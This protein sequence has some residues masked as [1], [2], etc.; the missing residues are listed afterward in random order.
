M[1]TDQIV[2]ENKIVAVILTSGDKVEF[3]PN[4]AQIIA[5]KKIIAGKGLDGQ[6]IIIPLENVLYVQVQE[7]DS[8]KAA[9]KTIGLIALIGV[10]FGIIM[11]ATKQSCPFIYSYDGEQYVFDGEPLGGTVSKGL[12]RSDFSRLDFLKESD[13][14]YKLMVTNEVLETQFIDKINLH[15]V[16]HP[17]GTEVAADPLG[18]LHVISQPQAPLKA[19]DKAGND[20][21]KFVNNRDKVN[22]QSTLPSDSTAFPAEMR[23]QLTFTF[24][25]P[26]GA[27]KAHIL[28]NAGTALWGSRMIREILLLRGEKVKDWYADIDAD[29]E[30]YTKLYNWNEREELF[31][32]KVWVKEKDGWHV[33]EVFPAGG[34]LVLEDRVVPI[35]LSN[36][37]GDTI[38]IRI[39]PPHTF[40]SIDYVGLVFEESKVESVEIPIHDV[41]DLKRTNTHDLLKDIDDNYLTMPEVG[42]GFLVSFKAP[43]PTAAGKIRTVF[44]NTTGYYE[45]HLP[46]DTPEE[47]AMINHLLKTPDAT[48]EFSLRK[49]LEFKNGGYAK[50]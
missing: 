25:K 17:V 48:V 32:L 18:N 26:E 11:F 8:G 37:E 22:W 5:E 1:E 44:A 24:L 27:E 23:A 50:K 28:F 4:G 31:F 15:Y 34:P 43:A 13:G 7:F 21:L 2:I 41:T 20:L 47:T 10:G 36:I 42:E 45:L 40:W 30:E 29:G 33:R 19:V 49:Y 6:D 39:N 38:E 46:M 16:D 14:L 35:D 12:G 3:D 9:L